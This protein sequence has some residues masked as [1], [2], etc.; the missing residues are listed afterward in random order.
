MLWVYVMAALAIVLVRSPILTGG[1]VLS[2]GVSYFFGAK[3]GVWTAIAYVL[4]VPTLGI[5][6]SLIGSGS[7]EERPTRP[8]QVVAELEGGETRVRTVDAPAALEAAQVA[9]AEMAAEERARV[10]H[11]RVSEPNRRERRF[12]RSLLGS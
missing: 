8:F 2:L 7:S 5:S 10:D 12:E 9:F 3:A 1:I 4:A 11:V 6:L